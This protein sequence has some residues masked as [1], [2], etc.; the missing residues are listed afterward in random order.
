M[1]VTLTDSEL[2]DALRLGDT[3]QETTEIARLLAYAIEAVT[4]YAP[5][6][7]SPIHDEAAIRLA[8]YLYDSPFS[9]MGSRYSDPMRNSGAQQ[10]LNRWR[11]HRAGRIDL[12]TTE[13]P[14]GYTTIGHR[15]I[16]ATAV[17][18]ASGLDRGTYRAYI[19]GASA[20]TSVLVAYGGEEA[21]TDL[22][23]YL[24]VTLKGYGLPGSFL[25]FTVPGTVW[26]LGTA[27]DEAVLV[28]VKT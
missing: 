13:E 16:G 25:E 20:S 17:D 27:D 22:D 3:G 19:G 15:D 2:R 23:D 9:S 4:Q 14:M 1:A 7:P 21:P 28:L 26:V 18:I 24:T 6:A 10:I 8:G 5:D 11:V 12:D